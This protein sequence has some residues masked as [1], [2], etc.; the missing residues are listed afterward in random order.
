MHGDPLLTIFAAFISGEATPKIDWTLRFYPLPGRR[1]GS[2]DN[3]D[4]P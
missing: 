3:A 1:D 2:C 4:P